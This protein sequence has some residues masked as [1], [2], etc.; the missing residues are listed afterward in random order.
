MQVNAHNPFGNLFSDLEPIHEERLFSITVASIRDVY[1]QRKIARFL[2]N[3]FKD[4]RYEEISLAL[5]HLPMLLATDLN[6]AAVEVLQNHLEELGARVVIE[7]AE[8]VED[9]D[10]FEDEAAEEL[11]TSTHGFSSEVASR[12]ATGIAPGFAHDHF[13]E[14]HPFS[15]TSRTGAATP[16]P[17]MRRDEGHRRPVYGVAGWSSPSL[18]GMQRPILPEK[19]KEAAQTSAEANTGVEAVRVSRKEPIA[20]FDPPPEE[21]GPPLY[22]TGSFTRP[23]LILEKGDVLGPSTSPVGSPSSLS[24]RISG[25]H[26]APP[27]DPTAFSALAGFSPEEPGNE[28]A[29]VYARTGKRDRLR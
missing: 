3:V 5:T 23:T 11:P 7:L 26:K 1:A 4:R 28:T 8:D 6:P 10:L 18:F 22:S 12:L 16:D 27:L 17:L 20:S 19:Q 13:A 15:T 29:Y 21:P 25:L 14:P 2:A 9:L 24:T